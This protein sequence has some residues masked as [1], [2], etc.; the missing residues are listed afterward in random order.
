MINDMR[1]IMIFCLLV[2]ILA[3]L[4]SSYN[5]SRITKIFVYQQVNCCSASINVIKRL[6]SAIVIDV[7]WHFLALN[8]LYV[9]HWQ[10]VPIAP[11][12][13]NRHLL[14]L[15]CQSSITLEVMLSTKM[16]AS[17]SLLIMCCAELIT[18]S[19]VI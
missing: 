4:H 12:P 6:N 17:S 14:C 7:Y 13:D 9:V 3:S 19:P 1:I 18:M 15:V 16:L 10:P 5:Y 2:I 11:L 8:C